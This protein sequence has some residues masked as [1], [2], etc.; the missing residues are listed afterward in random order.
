MA[1][2][3]AE[4]LDAKLATFDGDLKTVQDKLV[5]AERD[6]GEI[7]TSRLGAVEANVGEL[8]KI[9][10]RPEKFFLDALQL[11]DLIRTANPFAREV[12]AAQTL[13]GP[14]PTPSRPQGAGCQA[15]HGVAT[16]GESR[17]TSR[18]SPRPS[19]VAQQTASPLRGAGAGCNRSSRAAGAGD[20]TRRCAGRE[21]RSGPAR[22][23]RTSYCC[24]G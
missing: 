20:A 10:R 17:T 3:H 13:A 1:A 14:M 9:D 23:G 24:W 18:P 5:A 15:D 16:V 8:Q 19:A 12:A 11:R 6:F 7:L 22:C 21:V 2:A 4:A